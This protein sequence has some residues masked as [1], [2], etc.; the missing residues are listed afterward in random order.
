MNLGLSFFALV[1]GTC[2]SPQLRAARAPRPAVPIT[3]HGAWSHRPAGSPCGRLDLCVGVSASGRFPR[4][5]EQGRTVEGA[6]GFLVKLSLFNL[7]AKIFV[8]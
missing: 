5:E 8:L 4:S 3:Q 6:V 2:I 7:I 1:A